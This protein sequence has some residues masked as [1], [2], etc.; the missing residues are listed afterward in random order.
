METVTQRTREFNEKVQLA[1]EKTIVEVLGARALE[2]VV[3]ILRDKYDV[4]RDELPYRSE[5]LYRVLE[6]NYQVFGAK[7]LGAVIAR[8]LFSSLGLEFETHDGYSLSD[9]IELAKSG[10]HFT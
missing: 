8:K 1:V 3:K 5:T 6:E 10:F 7:T 2:D 9:Y 4:S